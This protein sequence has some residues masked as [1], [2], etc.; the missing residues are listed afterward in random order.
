MK[1]TDERSEWNWNERRMNKALMKVTERKGEWN[2]NVT[3]KNRNEMKDGWEGDE[4]ET[5]EDWIKL[6]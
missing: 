4:T 3:K 6:M 1:E 2:L 5:K